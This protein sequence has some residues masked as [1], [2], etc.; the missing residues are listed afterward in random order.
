MH[1]NHH[2]G[3]GGW[4]GAIQE[5]FRKEESGGDRV[6]LIPCRENT[7]YDAGLFINSPCTGEHQEHLSIH[8]HLVANISKC[9]CVPV[10]LCAAKL[11]H[12]T[13]VNRTTY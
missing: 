9:V 10:L 4:Q 8:I 11:D 2:Y 3:G 13:R 7:T 1:V 5:P 6:S 12:K